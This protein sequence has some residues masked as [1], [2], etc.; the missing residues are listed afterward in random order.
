MI[1]YITGICV[2]SIIVN[3]FLIWYVVNLLRKLVYVSENIGTFLGVIREFGDHL[4]SLHEMEI[5]FGDETMKGLIEHTKFVTDEIKSF[6]SVYTLIGY[7]EEQD[8]SAE[9]E[10]AEEEN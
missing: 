1:W 4:Q 5:F 6:E 10:E 9:T 2:F 8:E 7:E 3:I